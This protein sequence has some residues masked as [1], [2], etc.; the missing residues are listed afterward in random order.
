MK[1]KTMLMAACLLFSAGLAQAQFNC[2]LYYICNPPLTTECD[3]G[4]ILPDGT[5]TVEIFW[6]RNNNGID[7]ADELVPVGAGPDSA[8]LNSIAMNGIDY[9]GCEGGFYTDPAFTFAANQPVPNTF[10]VRV[11]VPGQARQWRS[12]VVAIQPGFSQVELTM[13]CVNESCGDCTTPLP[14]TGFN[15]TDS[16]CTDVTLT[17]NTYPVEPNVNSFRIFRSG[18][19][20]ATVPSN[21]TSYVDLNAVPGQE[22][23]EYRLVV[24]R[25]CGPGDTALSAGAV[26]PGTRVQ[27]ALAPA[28]TSVQV[29]ALTSQCGA[30]LVRWRVPTS[31]ASIDSFCVLQNGVE[32]LRTPR[33]NIGQVVSDTVFTSLT[34]SQNYAVAGWNVECGHGTPTPNHPATAAQPPAAP[35]NV[36]AS[37]G[38]CAVTVTWNAVAGATNYRVYRENVFVT[39][40]AP[41]N[42]QFVDNV[43]T[44]GAVSCYQISAVVSGNPVSCQ[45][46]PRS[47]CAN[48]SR[49]GPPNPPSNVQAS[50]S[51]FCS[52]IAV[53]WTDNSADEDSFI[54]RRDG[55]N[56]RTIGPNL[57]SFN[58]S[59]ATPGVHTYTVAA[60]NECGTSAFP[61]TNNGYK[62]PVPAIVT[63]VNA[64]DN[65]SDRV[66]VTWVNVALETGY[67]IFRDGLNIGSVGA[68]VLT[69]DDTGG[70]PNV[71]YTYTVQAFNECG[72]GTVSA[73]NSG[74]RV[75]TV[76]PA[77]NVAASDTICTFVRVTWTDSA[78]ETTYDIRRDGVA[79]AT[80]LAANTTS[81]NDATAVRGQVYSY[82]VRANGTGGFA[83]S[84][85]DNGQLAPLPG[86]PVLTLSDV[87][88]D[89]I[90]FTW[91][92][93]ANSDSIAIYR[94]GVQQVVVFGQN[95]NSSIEIPTD[96]THSY[97]ALGANE[98][99]RG[100]TSNV[101][102]VQRDQVPSPVVDL[103][104]TSDDCASIQITWTSPADADNLDL[105]VNGTFSGSLAATLS[106]ATIPTGN[107]PAT[108]EIYLIT[109]NECGDGDTSNV[110]N[111]AVQQSP[112]VPTGVT[113]SNDECTTVTVAWNAASGVVDGYSISRDG[114]FI[115]LVGPGVLQ[116]VD[117][118][119][120]SDPHSYTVVAISNNCTNSAPSSAAV[121]STLEQVGTPGNLVQDGNN[122]GMVTICWTAATGDLDGYTV[123]I[124]G[125]SVGVSSSETLCYTY[126]GAGGVYN[127][128]V[129]AYSAI[130][131]VGSL[132][133]PVQAVIYNLPVTPPDFTASDDRCDGVLLTWGAQPEPSG[134]TGYTI[135]RN[136]TEIFS[137]GS[138][139]DTR[140]FLD[141]DAELGSNEYSIVAFSTLEDCD[142]SSAALTTGTL[143][144]EAT[145][146]TS[147]SASDTSCLDVRISWTA[148]TGTFDGYV[149]F[150]A[151]TILDTV[152]APTTEFVDNTILP[153]TTA[154]YDV[155][156]WDDVC[157][158]T[159]PSVAD[160]GTRLEGP[161][162]PTGVLA[163]N[164]SCDEITITW[165][166]APGDVTEYRVYRDGALAGSTDP[167]TTMFEDSPTA[168]VYEYTVT[169]FSVNC[170][171]TA[172]SLGETGERL[173]QMGQMTVT[174]ASVDSCNGIL[175]SWATYPGAV[176]YRLY[177]DDSPTLLAEINAPT[178]QYF[179]A[180]PLPGVAHM[181]YMTAVNSCN[182]GPTSNEVNG[183]RAETPEQVT[184]LTAT[185]TLISQV[186]LT[187]TD[188]A[189]E[190]SYIIY[191]DGTP[192]DT[193][194]ANTTEVCDLTATPGTTYGYTV[195]ATNV[196]GAGAMSDEVEGVAVFSLGQVTGV[197][198]TTTDC[199]QI[200]LTW[201]DIA[202]ETNY[203]IM[204]NGQPL[205]TV[206]AD[207]VTY[208]DLTPAPGECFSYTVNGS[209]IGGDGPLS[210][211]VEGC[212]RTIP[213]QV[214]G[215]AATTTNC[216][217]VILTW[218][219]ATNEDSYDVYRDGGL[220]VQNVPANTVTYTDNTA[221]PGV[222][223]QYTVLARNAC[224]DAAQS[225]A[226]T[227]AVA[228]VPPVVQGVVASVDVCNQ[229]SLN[230]TDQ[231]SETGYSIYRDGNVLSPIGTVP[232]NTTFYVD[233]NITGVH[234]YNVRATNSCGNGDLGNAV[235]GEGLT[236]PGVATNVAASENCGDVTV[237]WNA[238][239]TLP[240][241]EYRVLRNGVQVAIVQAPG[242]TYIDENLPAGS[243]SYRVV[244]ANVC[245]AGTQSAASNSVT[246]IATL[247]QVTGFNAV[248]SPCFCVDLTWSNVANESGFYIYCD[249]VIVDTV[250]ANVTSLRY[251]PADTAQCV[252]QVAAFNGCE[253]GPLS[254]T[255]TVT[256]N[257]YPVAVTG[258]GASEN[259]CDRVRLSWQ[260][261]SQPGVTLFRLERNGVP[262]AFV[263]SSAVQYD[264]MGLW[265]QSTYQI[266]ALRVCAA[267]DTIATVSADG[268]RTAPT[269]VGPSQMGASDDGCG[270][271]TLTFTFNNVDGQDSVLI[272]R[273]G[274]IIQRLGPSTI[275]VQR[276]IVDSNPL[277]NPVEYEV[278]AVSNL[279]GEG[280]CASDIGQAAPVAGV[281]TDLTASH[282]RC[283]SILLEWVGTQHAQNYVVRRNGTIIATV[284]QGT[285]TY[286]D[287]P[288]NPGVTNNYTVAATN[289]C[290]S[291]PQTPPTPG[292]TV[293]LPSVPTGVN[294]TDGLCNVVIVSWNEVAVV[295][296]YHVF[297]N[298]TQIAVVPEG[299]EF[300]N[301]AAVQPGVTYNYQVRGVNQCGVG[302]LSAQTPGFS[303][304]VI[305][306]V[307]NLVASINLNDR[308]HLSWNNVT[309]EVGYEILR[310]FPAQLIATV[311]ADVTSYEDFS[312]TPGEEY[313]YRVRAFNGCGTGAAS[314]VAYGYRVPV[315]PIP[316]GV[317]TLTEEMFGCMSAVP[318]DI[319]DDGD[320][321]V[322]AAGMFADKVIW[323]ENNGTWDYIPHVVVENWD[324]ARSVEVGDIDDDGDLDIAAVA[325]FANQLVWFRH[326]ANGTFSTL[327]IANNYAGARDVKIVDLD[328]DNDKD[329]VT[330]ACDANDVSWWRN[331]G[332]EVF[333]RFV[334]DND[335]TGAR[336]IELADIGNDGDLDVLGAAYEGGMLAWWSNNGS[337]AFTRHVLMEDVYGA[338]YINAARLNEDNVLDIY[339]CVAQ[340]P[341]V[342]WWDGATMEQNYITS[343]VPFPRELDA[344][345]M[346][347]DNR[348][349]LLM[350]AN[351]NQEISWWRNTDNRFYRN[352]ITST[353]WQASVVHGGDF[354]N[355]GDTDVLGAGE[356]TIKI[357]LSSL[358]EDVHA[359]EL[360][361]IDEDGGAIQPQF[362]QPVVPVN[363][364][365]SANYPNP[366]NPTT[367]IR[368]GLPEANFV[369]LTVYDVT[370]RE[371]ARLAEADFGAGYHV[372][373]F[374]GTTLGSGVYFYRL[375]AGDF[376][377]SRKMVLM[378]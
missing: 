167:E 261:Y 269:P 59:T 186:C 242:T 124:D 140:V 44:P 299:I 371:V 262:F 205:A 239:S 215:L 79:I 188:V 308:V 263:P 311:G 368:F 272:K 76:A 209:N 136:G 346:D 109:T 225:A 251:C 203:E 48:G 54:V 152:I 138:L 300:Y 80:G 9:L 373:N 139:N 327:V 110:I 314:N 35:G 366:F 23:A 275:N 78:D 352:I 357:W 334:I 154:S 218:T 342:A 14:V 160:N 166:P 243:F 260:S 55:V 324:G 70:T 226:V 19:R 362:G 181:Y 177:R 146:P 228:M 234:T 130:C 2:V 197:T 118:P 231:L 187:W 302:N 191:R 66:T 128:Q 271:V 142:N 370:G 105:Y 114:S 68:D 252:L 29:T 331:N 100:D 161:D 67:T 37:N 240:I 258:F 60:M 317:I 350:A 266:H 7:A 141:V 248:A 216:T 51:T 103:A 285:F 259:L 115:E 335:F 210:V 49:I 173:P 87:T 28:D 296:S 298:G 171:E 176:S 179:D 153:G 108:W 123:Y 195:A 250:N 306:T 198:A 332:S 341:L 15:A 270:I 267:G 321:D 83:D 322:V 199:G 255:E 151:G 295:D 119:G 329:L 194:P 286:T 74:I 292:S 283:T 212:R 290:G 297:R 75:V 73:G 185:T 147:V 277:A 348:A 169:A 375:E 326:N 38:A 189:G 211:A 90:L 219:D 223:Y 92:V 58:D 273:D 98:C 20:I 56:L 360:A 18:T 156:A 24:A 88:C 4:T 57:L 39:T 344:V 72:N 162:A 26:D 25:D 265:P 6:D 222:A 85:P 213:T 64:T 319:D 178:T 158:M 376:I 131:G 253:I 31:V 233:N 281:V 279:C 96:G 301:D 180:T 183:Q 164:T 309:Q 289:A 65:L 77:T 336:S 121:G 221:A 137:G 353:L 102:T 294:A 143:L 304:Q 276:S 274:V 16:S 303:A 149:V 132:T 32:V 369:R 117:T 150:R 245:G 40:V 220:L 170:G 135:L 310:G 95:G 91:V 236:V 316:F 127:A 145:P 89:Q 361:P 33:G 69:F 244:T 347:D 192:I 364:E 280:G 34:G 113:A 330:A 126:A 339:F 207:V 148:S 116:Y 200:C 358:A 196:C 104:G 264:H 377:A 174:S 36:Q 305:G 5:T 374:D 82:V 345:D 338:S 291:G 190:L 337:E 129:A 206:G 86:E 163:S 237:T 61:T 284:L 157:G 333:T 81:Y 349:D 313:E 227:G 50:D 182:E 184:G 356:G 71:T 372:V 27:A 47:S 159:G 43:A 204:R 52:H 288:L 320:M 84:S 10:W 106:S 246:V 325:Q 11:C 230:W 268:G 217:V 1:L 101:L 165:D 312:A 201:T 363:Y 359:A 93:G 3:G 120:D 111:V 155:R 247:A 278:C 30:V 133:D 254:D 21:T 318:A 235:P 41:P 45:E 257:T 343:L 125:D 17:W 122:C 107:G 293:P 208:C 99:G 8:N 22:N 241:S 12:Q 13:T 328:G 365:L 351:E 172:P 112:T 355:D 94:D 193:V 315:N 378:K 307:T 134:E 168:G 46:G 367:Q 229:I 340:E 42:T 144:P 53:T 62:R 202:N 354:D 282:N 249:G 214:T 232:A 238:P 256:P 323:Y 224:G 97:Y 63:G 287:S 175:V